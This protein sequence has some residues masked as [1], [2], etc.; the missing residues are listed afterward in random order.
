MKVFLR[1]LK[2]IN[3]RL[4]V[5]IFISMLIPT[6]YQ[7]VRIHFLGNMPSDWGVN[8]ASQLL[9]V[10]LF[11]EIIQ[12]ALILPLFF[13]LGKSLNDKEEFENKIKTGLLLTGIIYLLLSMTIIFFTKQIVILMA[14][15][16]SLIDAT[17]KYVR[18]ETIASLFSTLSR[19]M[20]LIFITLKK[21]KY[22]YLLLAVQM[23]LS[24]ILDACLISNLSISLNIGVNGIAISNI[25]S[26]I[27]NILIGIMLLNK[28]NIKI[29][30]KKEMSF[31]W[32]KEWMNIGKYSGLESLIRNVAF[33]IMIIRM[34]NVISEQGSYW[35]ANNFIW[36]WLL[37][38]SLALADLMK[39]EI[40]EDKNNIQTNTFGYIILSASFS[41]LW[42][43]SMPFWKPFL[44]YVMNVNMYETVYKIILVQSIF[45]IIFIFNNI[46]DSAFYGAGRTDYMLIQSIFVNVFYYGGAFVLYKKGIFVPSLLSISLLFGIGMF[47]DF[48]PTIIQYIRMLKKMK[49][50]M[51]IKADDGPFRRFF[52]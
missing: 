48:I 36:Q 8:I 33:M 43:I 1:P 2:N 23:M 37:L 7:T 52:K 25:I 47:A 28:E 10:N 11:Y 46:C 16:K 29:L 27:I 14:Q 9:W 42:L 20:I 49:Y 45:Y 5:A 4:L 40:G 21:D 22:M 6:V 44:Y 18:L 35:I 50:K 15:N 34:V 30:N 32:V 12:E 17:V 41:F 13:I 39:K 38:P 26:N 24:I 51:I 19:F 3:Y 31:V